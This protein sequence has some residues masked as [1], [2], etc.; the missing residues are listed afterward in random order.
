M[1]TAQAIDILVQKFKV[2][3]EAQPSLNQNTLYLNKVD[4]TGINEKLFCSLNV[5]FQGSSRTS[6][7]NTYHNQINILHIVSIY[8]RSSLGPLYHQGIISRVTKF[9]NTVD[10]GNGIERVSSVIVIGPEQLPEKKNLLITN[11]S[12]TYQFYRTESLEV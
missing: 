3:W 10:I 2:F 1:T 6:L 4:L 5:N 8:S 9:F 11:L 7:G 12:A